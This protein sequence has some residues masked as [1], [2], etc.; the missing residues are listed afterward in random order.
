MSMKQWFLHKFEKRDDKGHIVATR[1]V[2]VFATR[3]DSRAKAFQQA[4]QMM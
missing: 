2:W 3:E 4:A 1:S